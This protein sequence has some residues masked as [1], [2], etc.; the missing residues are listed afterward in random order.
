MFALTE[1]CIRKKEVIVRPEEYYEI[2][3]N[4][5][6]VLHLGKNNVDLLDWK[7][8]TQEV[9]KPPGQCHFQFKNSKRFILEKGKSNVFV[10]GEQT[11]KSDLNISKNVCKTGKT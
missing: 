6:T 9:F 3:K 2:I 4:Y 7:Q 10:R 11:Y 8:A 5:G 1:R